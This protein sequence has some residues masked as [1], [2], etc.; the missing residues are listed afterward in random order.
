METCLLSMPVQFCRL[1]Q[2]PEPA[3]VIEAA[4]PESLDAALLV[5][6][7]TR[8]FDNPILTA[9]DPDPRTWVSEDLQQ[10]DRVLFRG[11]RRFALAAAAV[12]VHVLN[13]HQR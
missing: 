13:G 12:G 2:P 10:A 11:C 3:A 7:A 1:F 9:L 5:F 6:A 8:T 4:T